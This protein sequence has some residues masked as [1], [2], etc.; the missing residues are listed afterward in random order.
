MHCEYNISHAG[1]YSDTAVDTT[2]SILLTYM[3]PVP[4][5]HSHPYSLR[6][7]LCSFIVI[8]LYDS[9]L[10]MYWCRLW[11]LCRDAAMPCYHYS[12][13]HTC[14]P[15]WHASSYSPEYISGCYRALFNYSIQHAW[16]CAVWQGAAPT[17]YQWWLACD[18]LPGVWAMLHHAML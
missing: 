15:I 7:E 11:S 4:P 17:N 12:K 2:H 8:L 6:T 13:D 5:E 10:Y 1:E 9:M 16:Q 18:G 3:H 14:Y